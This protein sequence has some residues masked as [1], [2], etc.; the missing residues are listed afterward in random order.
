MVIHP[1]VCVCLP[2]LSGQP[3][4]RQQVSPHSKVSVA[5]PADD[6]FCSK[7]EQMNLHLLQGHISRTGDRNWLQGDQFIKP[8]K[9]QIKWYA[10]H[11]SPDRSVSHPG[12][13]IDKCSGEVSPLNSSL[14]RISKTFSGISHF[15]DLSYRR[16]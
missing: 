12:K 6:W 4:D 15:L 11:T 7:I 3:L 5:I 2:F 8:P 13:S 10:M 1:R 9:S 14:T 16:P